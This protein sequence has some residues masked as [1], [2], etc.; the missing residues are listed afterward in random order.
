MTYYFTSITA[1]YFAKAR[2]LCKSLK[3]YNPNAKFVLGISDTIP[4]FIDLAQEPFDEVIES[5]NLP[6]IK[7][8]NEF[9]FKHNITELCTAVKPMMAYQIMTTFN[10]NVIYL[11]PDIAVF[12]DLEKLEEMFETSSIL[13]TP[14][15]LHP[16]KDDIYVR[17]N[18]ILFLKRG[19]YNFGFF[20]VKNDEEGRSFL[21]WWT[22][23]LSTYCF[24][25]RYDALEELQ[26]EGLLGLFTDQKWADLIPAFFENYKI[27]R[28]PGYNVC[29]WKLSNRFIEEKKGNF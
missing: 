26:K 25:D 2:L 20:G 3:K 9:F 18:E 6:Q 7:N 19:T 13:L 21:D 10:A 23:R 22:D 4:K 16:E 5:K 1:N 11:D 8:V 29:T 14:H 28:E 17:E 24:D 12:D 15:Q 27:I